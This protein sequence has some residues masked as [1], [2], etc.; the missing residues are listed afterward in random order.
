MLSRI[1]KLEVKMDE[2]KRQIIMT[3][4]RRMTDEDLKSFILITNST[5]EGIRSCYMFG[6]DRKELLNEADRYK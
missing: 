6:Q 1:L 4:I 5:R 2:I 3:A